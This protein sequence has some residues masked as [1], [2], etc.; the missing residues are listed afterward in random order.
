MKNLSSDFILNRMMTLH[1]KV[2]DL[3]LDRVWC[4]LEALGNP[5]NNLPKVIHIAGTNGKGSTLSML[6][7]GLN[8]IGLKTHAYTSPHLVRFHERIQLNDNFIDENDLTKILDECYSANND[9]PITYFE[10]TTCAAIL[11]MSRKHADYVLL[12][13]GLGGRLDATNVIAHPALTVITPVSIDHEQFLGTTIRKIAGEKAGII[14]PFCPVIIGKQDKEALEIIT[15]KAKEKKA[16]MLTEGQQWRIK[17]TG[18]SI[19]YHDHNTRIELPLPNLLGT[20]QIQNAGIAIAALTQL[21][22]KKE[23]FHGAVSKAKWPARMQKLR[24]GPIVATLGHSDVWL[25]GGH[26][27]AAGK[28]LAN[29]LSTQNKK[30]TVLICGMLRTKDVAGYL[31]PLSNLVKFLAAV[32]IPNEQNTLSADE[33]AKSADELGINSKSF[34]SI[35]E[36]V[37]FVANQFPNC[38]VL[39]CGSLYLA[40]QILRENQ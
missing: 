6:R 13:V 26:N 20:H 34:T 12:E 4:L 10:I 9:R 14:K 11:A 29:Y 39:I 18:N 1:P 40:G 31:S 36:G 22:E 21:T 8:Q 7:A 38:Q 30:P 37:R 27:P 5:Q 16:P 3:T 2:I 23:A 15:E 32:S 24:T 35:S 33:T 17:Q 19:L 25:D 28:A